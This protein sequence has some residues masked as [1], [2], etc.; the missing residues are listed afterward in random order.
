MVDSLTVVWY[1]GSIV[2]TPVFHTN[3]DEY[4]GLLRSPEVCRAAG[5]TYRRLDNWVNIGIIDTIIPAD[6]SGSTRFF[7]P[8]VIEEIADL[9]VRITACPYKH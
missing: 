6:G 2:S 9:K 4:V 8:D 7:H 1:R 3:V 5:I